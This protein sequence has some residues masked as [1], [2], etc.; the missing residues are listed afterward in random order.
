MSDETKDA[1]KDGKPCC[2]KS[3]C[4]GGKA[5]AAFALLAL[6]GIGGYLGGRYC[7]SQCPVKDAP[8]AA[9]T[10]AK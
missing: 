2:D 10:P 6:G 3:R 8:A 9:V 5:L 1:T 7:P 4:C